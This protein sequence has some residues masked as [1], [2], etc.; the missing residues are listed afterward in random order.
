VFHI[1]PD[2]SKTTVYAFKGGNDG[3]A[4]YGAVTVGPDGAL[5]GTTGSGGG[6]PNCSSGCG[7]AYRMTVAGQEAVIHAF[8]GYDGEAPVGTLTFDTKGNLY[9]TTFDG[10]D[11]DIGSGTVF[12]IS[13]KGKFTLLHTFEYASGDGEH[14]ET[15]VVLDKAGN[16]YGAAPNGGAYG[17]GAVFKIDANGVESVL[18]SFEDPTG[19][20]GPYS[21]LLVDKRGNLYGTTRGDGDRGLGTVFKLT[22][23]GVM[24][25]LYSF[26]GVSGDDLFYPVGGVIADD[27]GNLYGVTDEYSDISYGGVYRIAPDGTETI[28]YRFKG[29]KDGIDPS[30]TLAA[31]GLGN[32]YGTTTHGGS[33]N[34]VCGSYGCGTV[35][36]LTP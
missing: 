24:T 32:I 13:P 5:Y 16:I 3:M 27:T 2:G 22:P 21:D 33:T 28:L 20:A 29:G 4:P 15:N 23:A 31:D 35:F 8:S 26:A 11:S 19:G 30:G 17:G 1:A 36:R 12:K 25:V 10:G 7:T 14:P 18:Y 34:Q 6:S 9:G